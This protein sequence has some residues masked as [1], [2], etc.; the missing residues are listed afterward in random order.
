VSARQLV[1]NITVS[2]TATVGKWD[3]V[4]MAAGKKGGIGTEAFT[5]KVRGNVDVHSQVRFTIANQVVIAGVPQAAGIIGDGRL[6]DG[7]SAGAGDSEYQGHFCGVSG[8]ITNDVREPGDLFYDADSGPTSYCG[9]PRYFVFNLDGVPT[10]SAP[11]SRVFGIWSLG[12]GQSANKGQAFGVQLPN[13]ALLAFNSEYGVDDLKVTR[14][15]SGIGPRQWTIQS[16]GAHMAACA[17]L[18]KK[19][20]VSYIPTGKKYYLPFAITVT[21]VP[22]PYPSFP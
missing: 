3:I 18:A 8:G 10:R 1:A 19:G 7:A 15:D 16:Q 13:C 5:V 21:E 2:S 6:A 11:L 9:F 20:P 22:Y 17:N 14:I 12:V 4:V